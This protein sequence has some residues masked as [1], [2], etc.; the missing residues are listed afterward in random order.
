MIDLD[1]W[2]A[3]AVTKDT[4]DLGASSSD[5]FSTAGLL[6]YDANQARRLR[7]GHVLDF[8]GATLELDVDRVTDDMLRAMQQIMMVAPQMYQIY[9]NT[10]KD[11]VA[12]VLTGL[13]V[14]NVRFVGNYSKLAPR[15]KALG[16]P[17]FAV[18]ACG[19]LGHGPQ[20][21]GIT[22]VDFGAYGREAFP[23]F[24]S[25]VDNGLDA[26]A[27]GSVDESFLLHA[28]TALP[29]IDYKFEGYVPELSSAQVTCAVISGV[30]CPA[31]I[32]E[33]PK[34]FAQRGPWRQIKGRGGQIK[35]DATTP[36]GWNAVQCATIYQMLSGLIDGCK[37]DGPYSPYYSDYYQSKGVRITA[38]NSFKNCDYGAMIRLSPTA[39]DQQDIVADFSA[40]DF[41]I[42]KFECN[43]RKADVF[44]NADLMPDL[45]GQLV[46]QNPPTRY[47]R[48]MAID[49]RLSVDGNREGWV[50]IPAPTTARTGCRKYLPW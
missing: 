40:E 39:Q 8:N 28:D 45:A 9:G 43:A 30:T 12:K 37:S 33:Y 11:A 35:F 24:M 25:G 16:L 1:P 34:P 19:L 31:S 6:Q 50:E 32:D 47:L 15:A 13:C 38:N 23:L 48:N 46:P 22:L 26:Y 5:H 41:V 18:C 21:T 2:L 20:M 14:K 17:M 42:E 27:L 44:L 49:E 7:S 29:F 4:L 36:P 3:D 10:G